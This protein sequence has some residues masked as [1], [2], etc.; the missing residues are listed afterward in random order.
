MSLPQGH[1]T[2]NYA[3]TGGRGKGPKP[4]APLNLSSLAVSIHAALN[5]RGNTIR[6]IRGRTADSMRFG[7]NIALLERASARG[8]LTLVL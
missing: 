5:D 4:S 7:I 8:K 2:Q 3:L 6:I 1:G